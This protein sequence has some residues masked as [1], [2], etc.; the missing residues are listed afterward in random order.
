MK[1][2]LPALFLFISFSVAA[3]SDFTPL[4]SDYNYL[5][6]RYDI[7][8]DNN[9]GNN[10]YTGMKPYL[11]K[12][13]AQLADTLLSRDS[14]HLFSK[15]DNTNLNYLKNDNWEWSKDPNAGNSNSPFLKYLY[16]KKNDFYE[17]TDPDFQLQI[18]PVLYFGV[19]K[20]QAAN[21]DDY[22]NTRGVEARGMIDQKVGFYTYL[23]DNQAVF[24]IYVQNKII[25]LG[26]AL[27]GEGQFDTF[28][29]HGVDYFEA[30]GYI[31]FNVTKHINI[32][33][34]HD[35][36][37]IGNGY[38]SLFLSDFSSN[39]VFL[40][41]T[42]RVWKIDYTNIFAKLA[43][44]EGSDSSVYD[45]NKFMS[46]TYLSMKITRKLTIGLF[47]NVTFGNEDSLQKRTFDLNY[48]DPVIF[49]KYAEQNAGTTD[50]V[51]LGFDW[52]WN[53]LR[54]FSLY[55]QVF[56][57]DFLLHPLLADQG[58][59][60]NK[61]AFQNGIKYIDVAGIKNLDLQLESNIVKPY[62]YTHSSFSQ[63]TNYANFS[64]YTNYQ[65]PL[66]HPDGANFYEF[67]TIIRYQPAAK[68]YL[69]AKSF[70]T[71][72]GLDKPGT[73]SSWGSNIFINYFDHYRDLGNYIAQG[74]KTTIAYLSGTITY[75]VKHN[76][77][78]DLNA[79]YRNESSQLSVYN[80]NTK[81][82]GIAFRWNIA[83]RLDEY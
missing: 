40:K 6:D 45:G 67:I 10:I 71:T 69:T 82:V 7:K 20:E 44:F 23:S 34:G 80:S 9:V 3:Q 17:H 77:F 27:P 18:N 68:I 16:E 61:Q 12:D 74:Y 73:D 65:Q 5:I 63:Y 78:I 4:N 70:Y 52:K 13:V 22:I 25:S 46:L 14:T 62:T 76:V 21:Y 15:D 64:N 48:L 50:K 36:N 54:H 11:R 53:F 26:K 32:Q 2:I 59:W 47:E 1:T 19:G 38:R 39:Y 75:E 60:V 66:A 24:P 8:S 57:D 30:R 55:G 29:T 41:I 83:Q 28:G 49:A 37:F 58:S 56:I 72:I 33:F 43:P 81:Y 51:H 79:I 42:T 31:T 35:K